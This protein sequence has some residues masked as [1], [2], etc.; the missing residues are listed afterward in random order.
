MLSVLLGDTVTS[1]IVPIPFT[2]AEAL[3]LDIT[4][5]RDAERRLSGYEAMVLQYHRSN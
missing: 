2:S 5:P 3:G 1:L 4:Q